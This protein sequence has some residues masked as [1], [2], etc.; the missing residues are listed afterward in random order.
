MWR[1][2]RDA[3]RWKPERAAA[4]HRRPGERS[5]SLSL[6][7]ASAQR[8]LVCHGRPNRGRDLAPPL[9]RA[10]RRVC[11]GGD[12]LGR[13]PAPLGG[14]QTSLPRCHSGSDMLAIRW[15]TQG[16]VSSERRSLARFPTS[17]SAST[18]AT[19]IS[20]SNTPNFSRRPS[21][22]LYLHPRC[23]GNDRRSLMPSWHFDRP[24]PT[25]SGLRG[26]IRIVPNVFLQLSS[27]R[28]SRFSRRCVSGWLRV[29]SP[30]PH[31]RIRHPD[32]SSPPNLRDCV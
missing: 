20:T 29:L 3:A 10:S 1:R 4:Q 5:M 8:P 24:R 23:L 9:E 2:K 11:M 27:T 16:T 15:T 22:L 12:G 31:F 21:R 28:S 6:F 13:D 17:R 18:T 14:A 30:P 25:V 26:P 7:R 32:N 19:L